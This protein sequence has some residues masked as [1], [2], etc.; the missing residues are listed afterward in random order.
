MELLYLL[1]GFPACSVIRSGRPNASVIKRTSGRS[2][3]TFKQMTSWVFRQ[4]STFTLFVRV[5]VSF[6]NDSEAVD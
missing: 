4:N 2:L 3:R 1:L 5:P 6:C